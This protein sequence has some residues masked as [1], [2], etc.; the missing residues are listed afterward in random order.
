[1]ADVGLPHAAVRELFAL[2]DGRPRWRLPLPADLRARLADAA[3]E[4]PARSHAAVPAGPL[5][6]L[7]AARRRLRASV[8]P[9]EDAP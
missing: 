5:A 4:L 2:R 8:A 9:R 6:R 1:M 3:P 7:E